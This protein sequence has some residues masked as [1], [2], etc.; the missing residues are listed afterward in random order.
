MEHMHID[1]LP[2]LRTPTLLMAFA[3]WNDASSAA[4][5]AASFIAQE[6]GGRR[7]ARINSDIFYNFQD[8]RPLVTLD[9]RGMRKIT[10]PANAFYA[11]RTPNLD[12]DL[13]VFLGVEP[14]L[15][16]NH[17]TRLILHM[18]R[19]LDVR[20][21]VTL[22]ALLADVYHGAKVRITGSSTNAELGTRLG[23][24]ASRYEGPT[25]IV[26]ILNNLFRDENLPAVSVWANTP[27]YVNVSPN[28]K[29]ALALI[30]R[31][32]DFLSLAFDVSSLVSGA[33]E[34]EEKVNQ[35]LASNQAVRDYVEQL[36]LRSSEEEEPGELPSGEELARELERYLRERRRN[37]EGSAGG[38]TPGGK[39]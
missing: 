34:F 27:H 12:H 26:G 13:V 17:F 28:P 5:T 24:R 3:G 7:F 19:Q 39:D 21:A 38:E 1:E 8:M 16:W 22:G 4:T 6:M 31:M 37:G 33:R 2:V 10:W 25:G 23:L 32:S 35:A 20:V 29:A 9:E 36:R 14:H 30:E 18:V 15:Q 11:C